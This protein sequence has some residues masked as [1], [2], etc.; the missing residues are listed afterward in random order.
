MKSS[1]TQSRERVVVSYPF[2]EPPVMPYPFTEP[3]VMPST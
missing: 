3:P 2:T 1:P